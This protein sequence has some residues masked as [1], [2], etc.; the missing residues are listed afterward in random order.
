MSNSPGVT[1]LMAVHNAA[2][3]LPDVLASIRA[4]DYPYITLRI[5]DNASTD[6]TPH[7]LER[8]VGAH[9]VQHRENIGFWAAIEKLIPDV[10]TPY[11]MALT[12]VLLAPDFVTQAVSTM[13]KDGTI[14]ALQAK[15]LQLTGHP[16]AYE[17][18]AI[19]DAAGFRLQR[20]RRVTIL[21]HGQ[22]DGGEWQT[23]REVFGVEGAVPF[24]RR[25]ALED[26]RVNGSIIDPNYRV[27]PI[28]YGDDFDLAW[29][30]RLRGWRQVFSPQVRGWHNRSTTTGTAHTPVIGQVKR[31]GFRRAISLEKRR[32]D[33]SNIRFTIVKNDHIINILK[34]LPWIAVR[35]AA[36]FLYTLLF[37]PR[38]FGEAVRFFRLLPIML[39]Q[40]KSIQAGAKVRA[41]DI[42]LWIS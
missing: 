28:G 5:W 12:D 11:V 38:V 15:V 10:S 36:V 40:R 4:Q 18:H 24:F 3:W 17:K 34:D 21:G 29:R 7:I 26:C 20:S 6:D 9:T 13:E 35:E 19:I 37:E 31:R 14:G 2:P 27:G 25:E 23:I 33:W 42:R 39:R 41:N 8:F 30:M 32:L 22:P 1:I 16:G